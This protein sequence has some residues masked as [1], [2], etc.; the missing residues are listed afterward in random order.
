[1]KSA[2]VAVGL[3]LLGSVATDARQE[4]AS[5]EETIRPILVRNCVECHGPQKS[6]GDLRLDRLAPDM[7]ADGA[8][9]SWSKV[10]DQLRSGSMP[11]KNKPR[12]SAKE[13][14]TLIAWVGGRLD[15]YEGVRRT[16]EGRVMVRR[17]NRN[18]YQ[19]TIRDLL[20]VEIDLVDLLPLDTSSHG[21]DNLGEAMHTSSFL[22]ERYLEAA[23][24]ALGVAIANAPQ[25]PSQKKRYLLKE[26]MGV[27]SATEKVYRPLDDEALV[28]FSS[29]PWNAI[30]L[31]QFYPPDRGR[32]RF[33]MS[34]S[35]IQSSGKP[36]VYRIDAG[37]MLMGTK[38][39]LV[40]Y[41][42]AAPDEPTVVEWTDHLEARSH[43]RIHP[44][45][46]AG[47]QVVN[48]VGAADYTGPGLAVQ[49]VEVEGPLHDQWPPA[50]HRRLF[51]DLPQKAGKDRR[52]EVVSEHPAADA[53]RILRDFTRR[54]FRRAVREEEVRPIIDLALAK[55][56]ENRS[57][58]QAVR[59]GLQ[60]VL[61]SPEFLFLR[62]KP[63]VLDAFALASRLS[64]FLW[65]SM[66]DEELM[67][68]AERGELAKPETLRAE[69][70]RLLRD[71][72]AAAFTEN[73]VGQWLALRDI[74]VTEPSTIL[75]PEFDDMLKVS[76]VRESQLF[77]EELLKNDLSVA[78]IV[79]SD[80]TMLNGRLARHY[81]IPDVEGWTFRKVALPPGSHRGGVLTMGSV[82]KVT[83]NGTQ[84]SPVLRGA[85]VLDRILGTPPPR[86]PAGVPSVEPDIR[87]ATTI[88]AQLAKHRQLET[89]ASC[90]ASIDPPGFALESFDV[91]GG[92][93][94]NYRTT[95]RGQEVKVD[96]RRMPYLKGPKVDP[97][98]VLPDGSRFDSID[99]FKALL[100][101]D[102]DQIARALAARLLTYA[103]G[104]APAGAD[105]PQIDAIVGKV[106]GKDYGLRTLVHEVVQSGLFRSK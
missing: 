37:P 47:A 52:L 105:R 5:F 101:R 4:S 29:S 21:F 32:Y 25:P 106:R 6:K 97:G 65:S 95:G 75:Y 94:E 89:C 87:G 49:W 76:M 43:I 41:Y 42:D 63:G 12:P 84:T 55:L 23:D 51:G 38:N 58:E 20:G 77:F 73:F 79:S 9:E 48:K 26:S 11:P 44:Y 60:A 64:Y 16:K 1:M 104:G 7:A 98:D 22:M 8:R 24:K 70:E 100:L 30:V 27:K 69:T 35:G 3:L 91:I 10:L 2:L 14:D 71:P 46:L 61:V 83:A 54:A 19:N 39:H 13:L 90:H 93:R 31:S 53:E 92:W 17:L 40:S 102:Q 62:E 88:R 59:V 80:F 85:W 67:S 103:T 74:D 66:P 96:G 56:G 86:P 72:K 36:V 81:G 34:A 68:L 57:F 82:L 33:R 45:G 15:S 28:M 50:S 18:E 99:A 78:N